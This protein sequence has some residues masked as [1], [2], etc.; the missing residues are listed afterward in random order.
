MNRTALTVS[1]PLVG[2]AALVI[3]VSSVPGDRLPPAPSLWQWDKLAHTFEY[4]VLTLLLYRYAVV[5]RGYTHA[6][7]AWFC[8][9][10]CIS[11]GVADELHQLLIPLRNCAWQDM[12]ADASGVAAALLLVTAGGVRRRVLWS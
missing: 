12:A 8:A 9:A 7:A 4:L 10:A 1:A 11:Y 6:R 5:R 2:W 3:A